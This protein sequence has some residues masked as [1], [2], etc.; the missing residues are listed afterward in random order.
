MVLLIFYFGTE[1]EE[2]KNKL[3]EEDVVLKHNI[4][5]WSELWYVMSSIGHLKSQVLV[6]LE[7]LYLEMHF[8]KRRLP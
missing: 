1:N 3:R 7:L 2:R 5:A 8:P 6:Y 4:K